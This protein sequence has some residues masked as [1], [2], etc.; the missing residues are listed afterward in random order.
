MKYFVYCRKSSEAEDRQVMS[1]ESQPGELQ[2]AF[3]DRPEIE[4]VSLFEES[5]SAKAPG[6]PLFANMLARIEKGEAAGI[7][8][9]APDGLARHFI[10]RDRVLYLLDFV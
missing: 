6:R 5:K 3:G 1:I 7:I 10:D 4:I 8:A 2:K 9:W